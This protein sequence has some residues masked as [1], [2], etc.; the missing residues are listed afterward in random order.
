MKSKR[1][2]LPILIVTVIFAGCKMVQ[3]VLNFNRPT[4]RLMGLK[5][6]DVKIDSA[7]LLFDVEVDNPYGV[8]LPL[9]DLDYS[10]SSGGGKF[11]SGNVKSQ[12]TIPAK[13]KEVV[14]L[15]A[16]INYVE[17]LKALKGIRPGSK[18]P[19][20]AELGLSANTPVLGVMRLPLKK[21]GELVLPSISEV[22]VKDIWDIIKPK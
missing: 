21:E 16:K 17:M 22:N 20:N 6:E 15:P 7:T 10:L 4:A 11:L 14:A 18:I 2:L 19:Y 1:C 9:T 12:T 8:A 3:D 5:I 13:S